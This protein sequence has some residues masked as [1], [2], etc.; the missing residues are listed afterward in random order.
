M[1]SRLWVRCR[2]ILRQD[3]ALHWRHCISSILQ[4]CKVYSYVTSLSSNLLLLWGGRLPSST[5]VIKLSF[6]WLILCPFTFEEVHPSTECWI[7]LTTSSK[8]S[9]IVIR[10]RLSTVLS[11]ASS[12]E[13]ST[14]IEVLLNPLQRTYG[15]CRIQKTS[16]K[17]WDS[18]R[19]TFGCLWNSNLVVQTA[20]SVYLF[21]AEV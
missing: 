2:S 15:L 7:S 21:L 14:T 17:V 18:R 8:L 10:I 6:I 13:L 11:V 16:R 5:E 12:P 9:S 20:D 1:K 19:D 4:S 3:C